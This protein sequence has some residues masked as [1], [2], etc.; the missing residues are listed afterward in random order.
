[1]DAFIRGGQSRPAAPFSPAASDDDKQHLSVNV[2]FTTPP[3]TLQALK[4][5]GELAY[6]LGAR[7]R[8]LVPQV[9]PYP[10]PIDRPAVDPNFRLR[11]FQTFFLQHPIET[12]ID[13]LLCRDAREC[14]NQALAP[15]SM[16]LIGGRNRFWMTRENRLAR[17][18]Q[19]STAFETTS[20]HLYSARVTRLKNGSLQS[21]KT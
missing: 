18:L 15:Q 11:Q 9:V 21:L 3:A 17:M 5:A 8:I 2:V 10:L 1:M 7:I 19:R 20:S 14:L 6:Q 16:V 13:V 4:R 12:H